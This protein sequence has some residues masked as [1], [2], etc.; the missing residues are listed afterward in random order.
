[1]QPAL[2]PLV[3]YLFLHI[4]FI[5]SVFSRHPQVNKLIIST[6]AVIKPEFFLRFFILS[7][8]ES[9]ILIVFKTIVRL[10]YF[11]LSVLFQE[12]SAGKTTKEQFQVE[13]FY[14]I[15]KIKFYLELIS[16]HLRRG[17]WNITFIGK[18]H[19]SLYQ[20]YYEIRF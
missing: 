20:E 8:L 19:L 18:R 3:A 12:L 9:V 11:Y 17:C 10:F 1:M 6:K 7:S 5:R 15:I 14:F 13:N 16:F 2:S 4:F